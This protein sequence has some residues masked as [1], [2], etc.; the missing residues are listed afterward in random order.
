MGF[1]VQADDFAD[2]YIVSVADAVECF[3]F[4]YGVQNHVCGRRRGGVSD[5]L[6]SEFFHG[7]V[8]DLSGTQSVFHRAVGLDQLVVRDAQRM[9]QRVYGFAL[10]YDVI[11]HLASVD[12]LDG[13]VRHGCHRAHDRDGHGD[14]SGNQ[15]P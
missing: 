10:A 2:R 13:K 1:G 11:V 5:G 3:V 8:E 4:G 7:E 9:C 12:R 15:M 14:G 6:A